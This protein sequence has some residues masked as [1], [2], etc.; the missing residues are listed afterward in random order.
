MLRRLY[1]MLIDLAEASAGDGLAGAHRICE[2]FIFPIPPDVMLIPMVLAKPQRAWLIAA[3][4][5]LS[6]VCAGSSAT[7]SATS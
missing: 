5:A 2:G 6:S 7:A 4:C 3:V 1:D